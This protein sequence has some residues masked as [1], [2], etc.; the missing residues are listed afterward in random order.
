MFS[1]LHWSSQQV[2]QFV[3]TMML[4]LE[5]S[6]VAPLCCMSTS[7]KYTNVIPV[8]GEVHL[9]T[10]W[11]LKGGGTI[12]CSWYST[13]NVQLGALIWTQIHIQFLERPRHFTL[14]QNIHTS[15]TAHP[16]ACSVRTLNSFPQGVPDHSPSVR[17]QAK[18][19]RHYN[20]AHFIHLLGMQ[21]HSLTCYQ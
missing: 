3:G 14:H 18:N 15:S 4:L 1:D 5:T 11:Q 2:L 8:K 10:V 12:P 21:T 7:Q 19:E 9:T 17:P 16:A 13:N 20:T 6:S